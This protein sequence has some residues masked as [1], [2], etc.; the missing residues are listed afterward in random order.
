MNNYE[1]HFEN[2]YVSLDG[3]DLKI[4]NDSLERVWN[5][6]GHVPTV[7]SLT[8]KVTGQE[9]ITAEETYDW[10]SFANSK[11]AFYHSSFTSGERLSLMVEA[12]TADDCGIARRHLRV[13]VSLEYKDCTVHWIHVIYPASPILRSFLQ[14]VLKE[15]GKEGGMMSENVDTSKK[16]PLK[17][18]HLREISDDFQ[19]CFP[20]RPI[21]CGWKSVT[22]RDVTDDFDNLVDTNHGL[23]SRREPRFIQGNLLFVQDHLTK[24]GLILIKEGP[25]PHAYLGGTESDFFIKGMNVCT[26]G[27]SFDGKLVHQYGSLTTYGSTVLLWSGEEKDALS[28]LNEYHH[29][30]HVYQPEKD[31]FVMSNTW[32]DMSADGRLSEKFLLDELEV[33]QRTGVTFYQI[34]DGWQNGT[35]C[36]SVLPGGAGG[37]GYYNHNPEFWKVNNRRFPNGLEP[38]I[39]SAKEKGIKMGLW[40]SPDSL[41]DFENWEKDSDTLIALHDQYG[42]HAFKLDGIGFTTKAGEE[43]VTR[44]LQKVLHRTNGKVVFNM[45]VTAGIRSGY[46]GQLQYSSLFLENRFTGKFGSWPNYFPHCTLRNIWMLSRYYPT[47]RLQA[48][49]LNVKR[50]AHLY[51][52]DVLAPAACGIEYSFAVTMCANP[53]AWMELTGLDEESIAILERVVPKYRTIQSDLLRGHVLPIGEEPNGTTWTGFQSITSKRTGCFLVIRENHTKQEQRLQLWNL[54]DKTV[55][56]ERVLGSGVQEVIH[57]D[58]EGYASF[59]LDGPFQYALYKY[60]QA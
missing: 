42:I 26:T 55:K 13:K 51:P 37:D 31:A 54:R 58:L 52:G 1:Y 60:S 4:G 59:K 41:N 29:A 11:V 49:F 8:N 38:I 48:E 34:D 10:L 14:V 15:K 7:V 39:V 2:C 46:Y 12:E 36:N 6:A 28:V 16:Q 57:I 22:F 5:V 47:H 19:D 40:F 21:H 18:G 17:S 27:W 35:S 9:W 30:I 24:N 3:N 32:G 43:N 33:A 56:L 23:F 50:N 45:D 44:F 53:L 20:L 25:T